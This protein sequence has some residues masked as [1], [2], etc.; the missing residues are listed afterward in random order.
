MV[1]YAFFLSFQWLWLLIQA[2]AF[3]WTN[4]K[5]EKHGKDLHS[6]INFII[7]GTY[8][9]DITGTRSMLSSCF[10]LHF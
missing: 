1:D 5:A 3:L 10:K 4:G 8:N 2:F 6:E 7:K 9:D